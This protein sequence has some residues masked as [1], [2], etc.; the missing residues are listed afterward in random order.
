[1]Y[2]LQEIE[3]SIIN[4]INVVVN[5]LNPSDIN[6]DKITIEIPKSLKHGDLATNA[7]LVLAKQLKMKP[8]DLANLFKDKIEILDSV[9]HVDIAG[10]GFI[11][12]WINDEVWHNQLKEI[13]KMRLNFG[14]SNV[15]ENQK[16]NV[17][18]VSANPTGPMHVGHS[19][20]AIFGDA[21]ASL[22]TKT[23][24]D[25]TREYYINDAGA[26]VEKFARSVYFRYCEILGVAISTPDDWYPGEY[27]IPIAQTIVD[28]YGDD[29][30][31]PNNSHEDVRI[32]YF[33]QSSVH[34]M[35]ALIQKDLESLGIKH[36]VYFSEKTLSDD[37]INEILDDFTS[38]GLI[39]Q[40]VLT[41]PKGKEFDGWEERV[42]T[43]FKSTKYG[44]SSDRALKK[45]DG[46]WTYFA[47]DIAYHNNKIKRGFKHLINV[48]GAD[49]GGYIKRLEAAI[50]AL[51]DDVNF[52]VCMTQ[53]V[54][55]DNMPMA[56]RSG[57]FIA[58]QDVIDIVGKDAVRFM[59]L[60]QKPGSVFDFSFD[61][62]TMKSKENRMYYVQYANARICSVMRKTEL[63]FSKANLTLL[64]QDELNL[65]KQMS[66]WPKIVESAAK[67]YEPHKIAYFLYELATSLHSLWNKG[68]E[69]SELRFIVDDEE[70]TKARL[71]LIKSVAIVIASGLEIIGIEPVE[72]M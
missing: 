56:K 23:G 64:N 47:S 69:N 71:A 6:A 25:V 45:E 35:I 28:M 54:T 15:G 43:L 1:M 10:P 17:E 44:D 27:L 48:W 26:Q 57:N 70:L 18:F 20:G 50:S 62:A 21:L 32:N 60:A 2:I 53:L 36:D 66:Y 29:W 58:V 11:N 52:S 68:N 31:D 9:K 39:Y 42:Q 61:D 46:S 13:L 55:F 24:W 67:M 33:T 51:D 7:A 8:L 19:R 16:V 5:E 40:G 3:Q 65:L 49:H 14:D 4:A 38:K 63:D 34:Q 12:F 37:E 30:L 41:P 72:R 59:M 22:L